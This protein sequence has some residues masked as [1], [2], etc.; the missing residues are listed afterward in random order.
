MRCVIIAGSPDTDVEFLRSAVKQTDFVICADKGYF[1]AKNADITP[2]L[3]IGD[4]DSYNGKINEDCD[5]ISLNSEK[6]DT[7]T[8][9]S[10]DV[11]FEMGY[12]EFLILGGLGGRVD[13]TFANI[14]ALHYIHNKG[15]KGILLSK[16]E[17][18]EFL[19]K[20]EYSYN[21]LN[22]K[23]FSIFAFGCKEVTVSYEGVKYPLEN[24]PIQ[25]SVP[26]G[27]SNIFTSDKSKISIYDGN[28]IFI[29]NLTDD[30]V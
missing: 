18:V 6:D 4:F 26:L 11:A 14:S 30:Y 3:I 21:N 15:G 19:S 10:I 20:G 17:K 1:F 12:T 9:H 7:D 16:Y 2:N 27:I 28:A 13:H 5:I 8:V 24:Y 25:S 22:G 23:T 29:L